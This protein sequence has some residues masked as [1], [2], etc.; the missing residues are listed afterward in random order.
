MVLLSTKQVIIRIATII[1]STEF[2]I[3]L[4]LRFFSFE[5]DAV[6]VAVLDVVLL[7][8]VSTPFIYIWVIKPFVTARDEALEKVSN[9]AFTDSLTQLANRRQILQHLE[10]VIATAIRHKVYGVLLV[11]DLDGFKRVNDMHGH[12][13]G[14]AVLTE[15][16]D[17]FRSAIRAED[18]AGRIGG[19]EFVILIDRLDADQHKARDKALQMANKLI[20]LVNIPCNYD[21]YSLHVGASIGLCLLGFE[22]LNPDVAINK[23]DIAMYQAKKNGK[24]KAVFSA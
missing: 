19:D 16:S 24:G 4:V 22:H 6:S 17:R 5:L 14:D 18:V 13:A 11:I 20:N 15:I 23:A 1:A 7:T 21:G 8:A 12:D 3:M 10:R 2:L 9:L